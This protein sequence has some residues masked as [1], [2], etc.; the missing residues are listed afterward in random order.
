[1]RSRADPCLLYCSN[2]DSS[3]MILVYVDDCLIVG[4]KDAVKQTTADKKKLFNI[5][6]TGGV[7]DFVGATYTKTKN[8][9]SVSQKPLIEKMKEIYDFNLEK[10]ATPC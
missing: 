1:M 3:V 4:D 10:W 6:E 7:K 5:S 2:M 9:F 8:G